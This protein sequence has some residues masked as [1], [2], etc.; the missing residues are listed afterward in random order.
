MPLY[1]SESAP[2]SM[3]PADPSL[4]RLFLL[5]M[6]TLCAGPV[7][8]DPAV[9][10]MEMDAA[11]TQV[12]E[13]KKRLEMV[14]AQLK[15]AN[16]ELAAV[17]AFGGPDHQVKVKEAAALRAEKEELEKLKA[18]LDARLEHFA[19]ETERHRDDLVKMRSAAPPAAPK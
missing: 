5:L 18:D 4:R 3:S 11:E 9:G 15:E 14:D 7:A 10:R 12:D 6:A 13:Q 8:C 17:Q 2:L 16:K 19:K 1:V